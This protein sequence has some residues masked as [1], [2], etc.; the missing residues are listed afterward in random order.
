MW[1]KFQ[2]SY[3]TWENSVQ[4]APFYVG[5]V[6]GRKITK[7][8]FVEVYTVSLKKDKRSFFKAYQGIK[9]GATFEFTVSFPEDLCTKIEGRGKSKEM[10]PDEEKSTACV[11]AILEKMATVG[12]GAY[13]RRFG[14]FE[15]I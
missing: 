7:P 6:N 8:D 10:L 9:R 12:L 3:D 2:V 4:F 11:E 15:Y 14:K 1:S 13:R 5:L